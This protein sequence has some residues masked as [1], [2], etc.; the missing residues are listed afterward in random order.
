MVP[1]N[2]LT[3]INQ[4]KVRHRT[5]AAGNVLSSYQHPA[6]GTKAV[7]T[8]VSINNQEEEMTN[9]ASNTSVF[10]SNSSG[11]I[12]S[13][14][15]QKDTAVPKKEVPDMTNI[16]AVVF[17]AQNVSG[18]SGIRNTHDDEITNIPTKKSINVTMQPKDSTA[19]TYLLPR[20]IKTTQQSSPEEALKCVPWEQ[21]MDEWW[22]EH[23]DWKLAR[24]TDDQTCFSRITM[25]QEAAYLRRLHELQFH[26]N[27]ENLKMRFLIGSGYAATVLHLAGSFWAAQRE[28]VPFVRSKHWSGMKWMYSP[29]YNNASND[30]GA[31]ATGDMFCYFLDISPCDYE[32]GK[33][34]GFNR[35]YIN[36]VKFFE[37]RDTT[38]KLQYRWLLS[39]FLRPRQ[40]TRLRLRELMGQVAPST[41]PIPC[42]AMHVRRTD[43][44][45]ERR[46][47]RNFYPLSAYLEKGNISKGANIVLLTDD[48]STIDEAHILHPEYNWLYLNRTRH[49]GSK[50]R[51][52]HIPSG[53]PSLELLNILADLKIAEK[54]D[55]LVHGT[56]NMVEMIAHAMEAAQNRTVETVKI[57]ADI[58]FKKYGMQRGGKFL[59]ELDQKLAQAKNESIPL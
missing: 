46:N 27:C 5:A 37:H 39:Y 18:N 29:P 41:V 1:K 42:T 7:S 2:S 30:F 59:Q 25:K 35:T 49:Y 52:S 28:N 14:M 36:E 8:V 6:A 44:T 53:D 4:N 15:L 56:S 26:S 43:A 24:E 3:L 58:D 12:S 51:D 45:S 54:C 32:V 21:N 33:E 9:S 23:P 50:G 40:E 57:D 11:S 16:T 38:T 47:P 17:S 31:C 13:I 20:S 19:A 22:Q 55:K 34:T 48:Q 10:A